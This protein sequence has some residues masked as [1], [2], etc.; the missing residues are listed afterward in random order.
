MSSFIG[1]N[2]DQKGVSVM[3]W[4][5]P[6]DGTSSYRAGARFAPSS[7]REASY[8]I[9]T[10]SPY[11]DASLD[12]FKFCDVG[13]I[14]LPI[15]NTEKSL[16]MIYD[17]VKENSSKLFLS[18]GGE[19][20]ITYPIIKA[21]KE[22]NNNELVVLVFDAHTDLRN[23][24]LGVKFS[25]ATVMRRVLELGNISLVSI[26]VR[27]GTKEEFEY[28]K[29]LNA[30]YSIADVEKINELT[31][32]KTLYISVDMDVFEPG[33]VPGVGNPEPGGINFSDFM[34]FL[35]KLSFKNVIGVDIVEIN[36]V[37]D[38]SNISSIFAAEVIREILIKLFIDLNN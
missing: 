16:G 28:I 22:K 3:L 17:F 36:P 32:G 25:H 30:L 13:N 37:Y 18:I 10:Y 1:A 7:I 34:N 27:A 15:G 4:G 31:K 26:G 38:C 8:S 14:E 19:H 24:Y 5:V 11:Q 21:L 9:E 20:L 12:E 6:F 2:L 35:L 33:Y 23:D 29:K